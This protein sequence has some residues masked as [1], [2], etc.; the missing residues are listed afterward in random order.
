MDSITKNL[1]VIRSETTYYQ[2]SDVGLYIL[3]RRL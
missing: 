2:V 3:Q 1:S